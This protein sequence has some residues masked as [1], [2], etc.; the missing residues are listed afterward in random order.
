M[1]GVELSVFGVFLR[2][3]NLPNF[4]LIFCRISVVASSSAVAWHRR[5]VGH[6]CCILRARTVVDRP[7]LRLGRCSCS[8]LTADVVVP[9]ADTVPVRIDFVVAGFVRVELEGR[10]FADLRLRPQRRFSFGVQLVC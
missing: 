5:R 6:C 7:G 3:E 9:G 1:R 8:Y 4:T 10:G 2:I